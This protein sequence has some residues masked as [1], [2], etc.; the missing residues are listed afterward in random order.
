MDDRP[1]RPP[2]NRWSRPTE[3]GVPV[4]SHLGG[5]P[6]WEATA[7]SG[8][9]LPVRRRWRPAGAPSCGPPAHL[10]LPGLGTR[11]SVSGGAFR[12]LCRAPH[13]DAVAL[14]TQIGS[15]GP[16]RRDREQQVFASGAAAVGLCVGLGSNGP[17]RRVGKQRPRASEWEATAPC[18]GMGSRVA[19]RR[20]TE[21]R[22]GGRTLAMQGRG[23]A[24]E[25]P[26]GQCWAGRGSAGGAAWV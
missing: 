1:L 4:G 10:P 14:C 3:P 13:L 25:S 12:A 19:L 5:L 9:L 6:T 2:G 20:N 17:V 18:V 8:R 23:Q 21:Q 22:I 15:S 11:L 16:L 26:G 24:G 7:V